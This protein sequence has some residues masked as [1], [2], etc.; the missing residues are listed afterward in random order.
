MA[1]IKCPECGNEVSD[2]A[3]ACIHCGYPLEHENQVNDM[4]G[5]IYRR[6]SLG[7]ECFDYI[8]F[9]T[10][11]YCFCKM[12]NGVVKNDATKKYRIE[13][14]TIIQQNRGHD[15]II[16]GDYL[17]R[18]Y[19]LLPEELPSSDIFSGEYII[20]SVRYFFCEDGTYQAELISDRTVKFKGNYI[21][22]GKILF[23][24]Q[25][26]NGRS[27]FREYYYLYQNRV[28]DSTVY[29]LD[30]KYKEFE[31][32][33]PQQY[34]NAKLDNERSRKEQ[35]ETSRRVN[36]I[37]NELQ[38]MTEELKRKNN[39]SAPW[40]TRYYDYPCPWCGKYKVRPAKWEDKRLSISFWGWGSH[41][42]GAR[43]KCDACKEMWE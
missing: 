12:G 4:S 5:K 33:L 15:L 10:D 34:W 35:A 41:K 16:D 29:I 8:K 31:L 2:K 36:E 19:Y 13:G 40:D 24:F 14:N 43:F 6:I 11:E 1:L 23:I 38:N 42:T 9:G 22:N 30:E 20:A 32:N 25:E 39:S 3:P 28:V 27:T 37:C 18:S 17:F 7:I 26:S 21:R